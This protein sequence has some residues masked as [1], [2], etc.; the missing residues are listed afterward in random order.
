MINAFY[1]STKI[2]SLPTFWVSVIPNSVQNLTS[3]PTLFWSVKIST[4]A[5]WLLVG[6]GISVKT[7]W[8]LLLGYTQQSALKV[9]M[10]SESIG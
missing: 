3:N 4:V 6:E 9:V 5:A 2:Q 1:S 10:G 8:I 7:H